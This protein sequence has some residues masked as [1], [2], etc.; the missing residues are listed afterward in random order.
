MQT[1]AAQFSRRL[2]VVDAFS[3]SDIASPIAPKKGMPMTTTATPVVFVHGLW[4]HSDTWKPWMDVFR[5]A[6]FAP[7]APGWPGDAA[8]KADTTAHPERVAGVGVEDVVPDRGH[9]YCIDHGWNDVADAS[10]S[11]LKAKQLN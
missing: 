8:T 2:R 9:S 7:I 11:W 3:R 10:L 5:A 6:G 4:M 1:A